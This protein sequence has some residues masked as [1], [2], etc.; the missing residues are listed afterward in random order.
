MNVNGSYGS[1][2]E[3]LSR[4]LIS[5]D[6]NSCPAIVARENMSARSIGVGSPS[7]RSR[8][9]PFIEVT[10]SCTNFVVRWS[11]WLESS[12]NRSPV[13][14]G[15][16]NSGINDSDRKVVRKRSWPADDAGSK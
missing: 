4:P 12:G 13:G 15:S 10:R 1:G 8:V 14:L 5:P 3:K 2:N 6:W 11:G 16:P 7:A 9:T